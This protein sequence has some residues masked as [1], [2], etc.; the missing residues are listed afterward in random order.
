MCMFFLK[1]I[2]IFVVLSSS[3]SMLIAR[4]IYASDFNR[5]YSSSNPL[6]LD[7]ATLIVMNE[8]III[9]G[10]PPFVISDSLTEQ[11]ILTFAANLPYRVIITAQT[12]L[13]CN[14]FLKPGQ[15]VTF[16]KEASL[17]MQEGSAIILNQNTF[18]WQDNATFL[19]RNNN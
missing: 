6:C 8:D 3:Q 10:I 7:Q 4:A 15:I 19:C 1:L 11:S 9:D 2:Y 16:T 12:I 17:W 5:N 14:I 13:K 18:V